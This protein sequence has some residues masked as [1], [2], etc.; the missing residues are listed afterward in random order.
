[1]KRFAIWNNSEQPVGL[2]A[3]EVASQASRESPIASYILSSKNGANFHNA[4]L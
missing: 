4:D 2:L 3:K 1:M